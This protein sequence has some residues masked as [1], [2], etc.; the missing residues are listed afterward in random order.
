MKAGKSVPFCANEYDSL[1]ATCDGASDTTHR[2][3]LEWL[4]G[5]TKG[6]GMHMKDS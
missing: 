3:H 5:A 1:L 2:C 4:I 6:I